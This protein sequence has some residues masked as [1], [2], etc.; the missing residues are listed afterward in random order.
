MQNIKPICFQI[1][2]ISTTESSCASKRSTALYVP[3][4]RNLRFLFLKNKIRKYVIIRLHNFKS[5]TDIANIE[6]LRLK[7]N[8]K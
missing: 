6:P 1:M 3:W 8:S 2:P 7:R 4:E 5:D